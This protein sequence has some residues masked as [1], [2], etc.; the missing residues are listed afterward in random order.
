MDKAEDNKN[1]LASSNNNF[2]E[3]EVDKSVE[4]DAMG[5]LGIGRFDRVDLGI[6]V[7]TGFARV[8]QDYHQ[9]LD[10]A[11]YLVNRT[12][13]YAFLEEDRHNFA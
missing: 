4:Y 5:A 1:S 10:F 6:E 8:G 13:T 9:V 12:D 2:E 3:A 11:V 7:R